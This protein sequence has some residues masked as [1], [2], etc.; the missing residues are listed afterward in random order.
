MQND[1]A[2]GESDV[3][4]GRV[5]NRRY[6]KLADETRVGLHHLFLMTTTRYGLLKKYWTDG[7]HAAAI[8]NGV[9]NNDD[10]PAVYDPINYYFVDT[11][12]AVQ[13]YA[14]LP[15]LVPRR[16]QGAPYGGGRQLV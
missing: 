13:Q 15:E 7:S 9:F 14:V 16:G 5:S 12:H 2:E 1:L 4:R 6:A 3:E 11:S 8:Q 10:S